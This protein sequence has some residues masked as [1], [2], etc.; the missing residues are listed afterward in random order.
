MSSTAPVIELVGVSVAYGAQTAVRGIDLSVPGGAV[1][2]LLGPNGAGKTTLLRAIAGLQRCAAGQIRLDGTDVTKL[3][4]HQRA[5]QGICL[6]PEGRGIF[7]SLTVA[8]NLKAL[9]APG[10]RRVDEALEAFPVLAERRRQ[11]AG[12]M[13]GGQQ[14]MLA[15]ARCFLTDPKVILLDEVSMGL[16]PLVVDQIFAS[17]ERLA[18]T[19]VSLLVVEQY[20]DRALDLAD[21]AH[22]L[23]HG[24][25]V[26]GGPADSLSR[27]ELIGSYLGMHALPPPGTP[28]GRPGV[29]RHANH[30]TTGESP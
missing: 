26:H 14:Q 5:R 18:A 11:V 8:E 3:A 6:I 12:T 2:A 7:R 24:D 30:I 16:A 13:S 29:A 1:T 23:S 20:V 28:P 10:V 9:A 21:H 25:L 15:L 22:V 17:I 19:G 27:E 4:A